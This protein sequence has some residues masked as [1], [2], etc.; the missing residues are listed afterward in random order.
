M[1]EG[2]YWR[3]WDDTLQVYRYE[4]DARSGI[5]ALDRGEFVPRVSHLIE[6]LR[7]E[8]SLD[9]RLDRTL[10]LDEDDVVTNDEL[11]LGEDHVGRLPD[12]LLLLQLEDYPAPPI[13]LL[14]HRELP[15]QKLLG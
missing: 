2:N 11:P 9:L 15:L 13:R 7:H 1:L 6:R 8:E 3:T 5:D 10:P 12:P 4:L 14:D